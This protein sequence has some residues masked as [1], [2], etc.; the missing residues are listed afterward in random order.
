MVDSRKNIYK[1]YN[2]RL[3]NNP[4]GRTLPTSGGYADQYGGGGTQ[5]GGQYEKSTEGGM[6]NTG[7]KKGKGKY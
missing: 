6:K 7:H 5:C 3:T 4:M 2:E 1:E